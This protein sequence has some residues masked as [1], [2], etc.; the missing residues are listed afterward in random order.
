MTEKELLILVDWIIHRLWIW[1]ED[2]DDDTVET[3]QALQVVLIPYLSQINKG[4]EKVSRK[5]LAEW[6]DKTI[7]L[8]KNDDDL[9]SILKEYNLELL[10]E[11][12][13]K[14]DMS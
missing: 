10:F 2:D 5:E 11:T 9:Q 12:N 8:I 13:K 7:E 4:M 14:G 3:I 1:Q 6:Q